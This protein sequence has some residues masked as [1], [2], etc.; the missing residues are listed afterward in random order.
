MANAAVQREQER[1]FD[2]GHRLLPI[3]DPSG[4]INPS[5]RTV[6]KLRKQW[7]D[8]GLSN[9]YDELAVRLLLTKMSPAVDAHLETRPAGFYNDADAVLDD[10]DIWYPAIHTKLEDVFMAVQLPKED[11]LQFVDRVQIMIQN[12]ANPAAIPPQE[13]ADLLVRGINPD[14][15]P[16]VVAELKRVKPVDLAAV[17]TSAEA[18]TKEDQR[19]RSRVRTVNLLQHSEVPDHMERRVKKLERQ[20][21]AMENRQ[22]AFEEKLTKSTDTMNS[23][24]DDIKGAILK[25]NDQTSQAYAFPRQVFKGRGGYRNNYYRGFGAR[26]HSGYG[27]GEEDY[28]EQNQ[29]HYGNQR[30]GYRGRGYGRG[31]R[32]G[33]FSD[34]SPSPHQAQ[35]VPQPPTHHQQGPP[36]P[37]QSSQGNG[38]KTQ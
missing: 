16:D 28:E 20:A 32:G 4:V 12:L 17:R 15:Y 33:D 5:I 38:K 30:G 35:Q 37:H 18:M 6:K 29:V 2:S 14:K 3:F 21:D 9:L 22:V 11:V 27:F 36:A 7:E 31:Q 10:L 8:L 13:V 25:T 34:Q 23:K 1:L 26:R 19:Y 24:L